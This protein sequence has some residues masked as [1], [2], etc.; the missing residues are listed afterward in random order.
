[1]N[2]TKTNPHSKATKNDNSIGCKVSVDLSK[3]TSEG[4]LYIKNSDFFSMD[5]VQDTIDKF[6]KSDILKEIQERKE[7]QH[8]N[9]PG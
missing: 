1:M 2:S 7:K 6:L 3:A 9:V 5:V 4:R 8:Q